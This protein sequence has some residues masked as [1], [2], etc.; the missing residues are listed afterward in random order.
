MPKLQSPSVSTDTVYT[1]QNPKK[2]PAH[3]SEPLAIALPKTHLV[4]HL[5]VWSLW[6]RYAARVY[7]VTK[8]DN[9]CGKSMTRGV[10]LS[11]K[12]TPTPP[13]HRFTRRHHAHTRC[14]ESINQPLSFVPGC[15]P[16]GTPRP[17]PLRR[18]VPLASSDMGHFHPPRAAQAWPWHK[19]PH[20]L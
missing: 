2:H 20:V 13:Q 15:H 11:A 16:I 19:P 17:P 8:A 12:S 1:T 6:P 7:R 3:V 10:A 4:K 18:V 5:F 14:I 9:S